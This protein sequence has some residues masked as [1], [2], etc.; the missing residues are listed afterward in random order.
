VADLKRA[1]DYFR[2]AKDRGG[3]TKLPTR[4]LLHPVK[5]LNLTEG[6]DFKRATELLDRGWKKS[7]PS[8]VK[9][10]AEAMYLVARGLGEQAKKRTK[11]SVVK[12][13]VTRDVFGIIIEE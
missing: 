5:H 2:R 4:G 9:L 10:A 3:D 6:R 1:E 13:K 12:A 11:A 7:E 8:G